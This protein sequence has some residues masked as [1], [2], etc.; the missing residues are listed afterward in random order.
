MRTHTH[1]K[2]GGAMILQLSKEGTVTANFTMVRGDYAKTWS[3]DPPY[4]RTRCCGTWPATC[5]KKCTRCGLVDHKFHGASI[6]QSAGDL[7]HF[8]G[9]WYTNHDSRADTTPWL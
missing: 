9:T 8:G 5:F 1:L 2:T 4:C 6:L 7:Y 3:F